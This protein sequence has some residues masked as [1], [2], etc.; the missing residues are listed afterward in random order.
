M[1]KRRPFSKKTYDVY[2]PVAKLLISLCL[3]QD[4]TIFINQKEDY[5]ADLKVIHIVNGRY[6]REFHE[7]EI[8]APWKVGKKWP[9][10][11]TIDVLKRKE[12][13]IKAHGR[14]KLWFYLVSLDLTHYW[15]VSAKYVLKKYEGPKWCGS[16]GMD[17]FFKVPIEYGDKIPVPEKFT[18][19]VLPYFKALLA[20][21]EKYKKKYNKKS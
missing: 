21:Y 11:D 14:A 9:D 16:W 7:C 18:I 20:E 1:S 6:I 10:W 4:P 12:K 19:Q 5:K 3:N 17:D 2:D 13:L 15:K 8:K